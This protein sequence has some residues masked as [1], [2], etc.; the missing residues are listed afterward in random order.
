MV[1]SGVV[2][3][4]GFT[5]DFEEEHLSGSCFPIPEYAAPDGAGN[6]FGISMLQRGRS[7]RSF[8]AEMEPK[9]AETSITR[10]HDGQLRPRNRGATARISLDGH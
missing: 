2:F 10:N 1:Q 9:E 3:S 5:R 8:W 7:Y 4:D 6:F